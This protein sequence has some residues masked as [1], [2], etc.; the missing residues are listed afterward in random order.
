M[1][2]RLF[3]VA[4]PIGN[5]QD[6]STRALETLRSVS[7]IACEDTRVTRKLLVRYSITTPTL[8]CHHHSGEAVFARL[9]ARLVAGDSIAYVADAG[10]P[11]VS[12][13][14]GKLVALAVAAGVTVLPIPGPSAVTAALSV[15]G[16]NTQ[17]YQ[18]F[19]FP[20]HKKGRQTFF[21][22]VAAC[23]SVVVFYESTHR[24]IKALTEL[25]TLQPQRQLVVCR[26]LTKQ[27]ETTYR[28]TAA[29]VLQQLAATSTKGEFVVVLS[30]V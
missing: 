3:L 23:R 26:E 12:D 14:G 25:A 21:R 7:L 9:V 28:G 30:P 1:S 5:L 22:E 4:T 17:R 10:T 16:F 29:E 18:F 11:G 19:G 2:G 27:F 24:I 6:I 20:P 15:A 13:P 8:S